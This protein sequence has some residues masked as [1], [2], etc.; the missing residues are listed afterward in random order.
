EQEP[1]ARRAYDVTGEV[2]VAGIAY[3]SQPQPE[4]WLVIRDKVPAPGQG[5][6]DK[7]FRVDVD[8]ISQQLAYPLLPV[9]VRQSPGANPAELP[10]REENFDLTEG[11]H[12]SYALQWFSFAVILLV[13]YG[14]WLKKQ[15]DDERRMTNDE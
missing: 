11:S 6:L 8:G 13:V 3:R 12:L 14:A 4:G 5:R 15:A 1:E 9:F 2:T 10:A 7:W